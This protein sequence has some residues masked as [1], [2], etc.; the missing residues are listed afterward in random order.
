MMDFKSFGNG[1]LN[2]FL[3]INLSTQIDEQEGLVQW[4]CNSSLNHTWMLQTTKTLAFIKE[5]TFTDDQ[6]LKCMSQADK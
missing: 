4:W 1:L 3:S 2:N 6:L 5:L